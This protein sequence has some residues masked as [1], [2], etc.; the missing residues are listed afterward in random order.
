MQAA[1]ILAVTLIEVALDVWRPLR[2][3]A[4]RQHEYRI[5]L[6]RLGGNWEARLLARGVVSPVEKFCPRRLLNQRR[7]Q[8]RQFL[9]L[10]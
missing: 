6:A 8:G 9:Q 3:E 4:F 2:I 7:A 10:S 5:M 1:M